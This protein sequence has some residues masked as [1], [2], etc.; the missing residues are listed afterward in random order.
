[1]YNFNGF[2]ANKDNVSASESRERQL[3]SLLSL[4]V[5]GLDIARGIL[6]EPLGTV[7]YAS[8]FFLGGGICLNNIRN[9]L[10]PKNLSQKKVVT[11]L[12]SNW[13]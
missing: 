3:V 8:V 1:M 12:C 6:V 4:Y 9:I 11:R 5:K 10:L 2:R 13:F 7:S